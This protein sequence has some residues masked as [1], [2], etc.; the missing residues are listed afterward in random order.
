MYSREK[1]RFA[2]LILDQYKG[3]N[4]SVVPTRYGTH[5]RRLRDYAEAL[6]LALNQKPVA[7]IT[8]DDIRLALSTMDMPTHHAP[9]MRYVANLAIGAL[10]NEPPK[11]FE[12]IFPCTQCNGVYYRIDGE[13]RCD[14]CNSRG[15]EDQHGFPI[16]FPASSQVRHA[17]QVFHQSIK[18]IRERGF[19]VEESYMLVAYKLNMPL[20]L[21]HAGLCTKWEEI[22]LLVNAT[23]HILEQ[24]NKTLAR[25]S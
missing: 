7:S 15:K 23:K 5:H 12:G 25:A 20:P 3:L 21:V 13:Y 8:E 24:L 9:Q 16:S 2:K 11:P 6:F 14:S 18:L 22:S 4:R 1:R 10:R 19:S 17:R